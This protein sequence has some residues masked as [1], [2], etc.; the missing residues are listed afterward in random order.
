MLSRR[1]IHVV[2]CPKD[3][4]NRKKLRTTTKTDTT[5]QAGKGTRDNARH[6]GDLRLGMVDHCLSDPK[7]MAT[8]AVVSPVSF[9]KTLRILVI[10]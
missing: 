8:I 10:L 9:D 2:A 6:H 1:G 4:P 3:Q 5:T 7:A